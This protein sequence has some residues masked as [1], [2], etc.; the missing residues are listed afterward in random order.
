MKRQDKDCMEWHSLNCRC[1]NKG[2]YISP[3]L[4]DAIYLWVIYLWMKRRLKRKHLRKKI[5]LGLSQRIVG[6][7]ERFRCPPQ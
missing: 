6:L 2:T 4:G 7:F 5:G 3:T 1:W